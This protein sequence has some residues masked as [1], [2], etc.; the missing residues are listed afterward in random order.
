MNLDNELVHQIQP[1]LVFAGNSIFT[2]LNEK[3]GNRFTY[4]VNL[5]KDGNCYFV[6]VLTG[7]SHFEYLGIVKDNAF[8]FTSKSKIKPPATSAKVWLWFFTHIAQL[9]EFIKLFHSGSCAKCGKT[10]TTPESIE[11]GLGPECFKNMR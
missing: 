6:S 7:P 5:S 3:T 4:K 11:I 10:L 8:R 1:S 9:P 2:L